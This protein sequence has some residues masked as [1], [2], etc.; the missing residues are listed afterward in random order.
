MHNLFSL[1]L[2]FEMLFEKINGQE[3][4]K[5]RLIQT[6]QDSR[7]SHAQLFL[8]PEGNGKLALAIA[9]AQYINC[10]NKKNGDACGICP[11]CI[12]FNKLEHPDLHFIF[13]VAKTA[14]VKD[15]PS[16]K[17]FLNGWR[18]FLLENNAYISLTGW[19][20]KIGIENKQALIYTEDCNDIIR[21]LGYKSYESEYKVMIIWMVEKLYHAAAPKILKILEEPPEKTLFLLVAENQHQIINTILSRTQIVKI[22]KIS[23]EA[24]KS[25]LKQ[26]EGIS[27]AEIRRITT[28]SDGNFS[29]ALQMIQHGEEEKDSFEEFRNWMRLCYAFKIVEINAFVSSIAKIGREKQKLFLQRA[30]GTL[31]KSI[32]INYKLKELA[33]IDDMEKDFMQKFHPFMNPQNGHEIGKEINDAIFHIERNANPSLVFMDLSLKLSALMH[34]GKAN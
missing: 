14:E 26:Q 27:D 10:K 24:M 21:T 19:Y 8:G 25:A 31:R 32:L 30:A 17:L 7:I 13:P 33:R 29:K 1:S 22:P 12:K 2:N 9:Y 4:V 6:V 28:Q 16:S 20:K 15:K 23:D 5:K 3:D 11:S 34:R 18:E